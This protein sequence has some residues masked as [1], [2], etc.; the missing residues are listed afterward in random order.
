MGRLHGSLELQGIIPDVT[1]S[2][3]AKVKDSFSVC[4]NGMQSFL[5]QVGRKYVYTYEYAKHRVHSIIIY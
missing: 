5:M 3:R 2:V 1:Q 4:L